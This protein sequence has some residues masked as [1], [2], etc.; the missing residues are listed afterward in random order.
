MA[1]DKYQIIIDV[2]S[3]NAEKNVSRMEGVFGGLKKGA[4][5]VAA[6]LAATG[7]AALALGKQMV[8]AAADMEQQEVAFKTLLG[9]QEKAI[10]FLKEARELAAKTPFETKDITKAAQ[11]ML[12]FGMA[13][14]DVIPNIK[15][16][17]DVALGNKEKFD[18]LSLAFAQVQSS[19]KLMGQDLLQMVNQ[20]FN[21]LQIMSEKSGKSMAQLKDEMSK[22]AISAAM[23][24]QAFKDATSEGGR[25]FG[26]MEAQSTTFAGLVSTLSDTWNTFLMGEGQKILEWAKEAVKWLTIFIVT[27]LPEIIKKVEE[28][29]QKI[30][31]FLPTGEEFKL[32][33][34][35]LKTT[36]F[37][38]ISTV[39]E[40]AKRF[41]EKTGILAQLKNV[42]MDLWARIQT[43]LMPAFEKLWVAIQP[44]MPYFEAFGKLLAVSF[45]ATLKILI[46]ILG[47]VAGWFIEIIAKLIEFAAFVINEAKPKIEL[48]TSF[49]NSLAEAIGW[50]I[51]KFNDFVSAAKKASNS[52]KEFMASN[53][54]GGSL[55]FGGARA[56]GGP[57]SSGTPYIVG[58]RGPEMFVPRSSGSIIPNEQ[59]GGKISVMEGANISVRNDGDIQAIASMVSSQLA[60]T[61][62]AQRSGLATAH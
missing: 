56:N 7:V 25:F 10:A 19:G 48:M 26:G 61:L 50:V 38:L 28:I 57:V 1:T 29:K 24:T 42:V 44:L 18:S 17:G 40:S 2:D 8:S 59:M 21:P 20:G 46:E 62:E 54:P 60:R 41:E 32:F 34:E 49:F 53:V 36:F 58:E 12:A 35:N 33:F 39:K 13:S 31:E 27:V 3:K 9:S 15:M 45:I 37:G 55:I 14:K 16:I 52:A 43:S 23:V 22:G 4:L 11:T 51:G 47:V 5:T 30:T 6:G